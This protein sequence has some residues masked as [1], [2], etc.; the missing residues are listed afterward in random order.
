VI[1]RSI[2]VTD[3]R[4]FLEDIE[5]GPFEEGLSII[6]APNGTGKSTLFEA[7]RRALLDGHKVTGKD[8]EAI[9]PWGRN[10]APKVTIEFIHDRQE[11]RITKQFIDSP[12]A[13]LERK[14][15]GRYRRLAEGA[16]ADEQ[17]REILTKNPP[18]KGLAKTPNW[19]IAQVLWAPQGSLAIGPLTGDVVSDIQRMLSA[20]VSNG[21]TGPVEKR[22]EERYFQLFSAKGK[23]K[24]GKDAPPLARLHEEIE[25]A[26][27]AR[28]KAYDL[29]VAFE[30]TSQR[31]EELRARRTQARYNVE[32]TMKA[33]R[34]A[35]ALA[36]T[37]RTLLAERNERSERVNATEAQYKELKRRIDLIKSTERDLGEAQKR[38]ITLG[39]EVPL[40][41]REVQE[42]EKEATR[43]K[44]ELE[45]IR[46]GRQ[47]VDTAIQMADSARRFN[48]CSR[49][50]RRSDELISKIE[51]AE[52]ALAESRTKRNAQI[53]PD[54]RTLKAIRKSIKDRDDAQLRIE[55]SL[56]TLE[57]VPNKDG[58]VEVVTGEV[59]G[60]VPLKASAPTQVRGSPEV[61]VEIPRVARL[62]AWGPVGSVE[63]HREAR[64][65]AE[66]KLKEL[67][68]PFGTSDVDA[69][70][71]LAEKGKEL[72]ASVAEAYTKLQTLLAGRT[73]DELVQDRNIFETVYR[74][75]LA[76]YPDWGKT[77]PDTDTLDERAENEKQI[78]ITRVEN[79]EAA[80]DKARSALTAASGQKETLSQR[81][82]DA[83][84]QVT[85]LREK[86]AELTSDGKSL[87]EREVELQRSTMSWEA[88]RTRLVGIQGQL[89]QYEDD[90][91]AVVD[92]LEAQVEAANQE[93]SQARE[94]EVREETKLEGLC[95]QG[96]YSAISISE[97]RVS[98]LQE[99]IRRDELHVEAIRLLH[100][101]VATCRSEAIAAVSKPVE[102]MATRTLQRI[103]GR[104]L[105]R[106]QVGEA[107]E[108]STVVPESIEEAVTLDN[109]SGGEQEQLYLATRL[110]L[111][112]VLGREER[113]LV[114]LDDVLT[115]TDAG[116]LAKV[117]NVL[118][119]VAQ[120]LQ[121]LIL[122]CHP[123]RY[124]SLKHAAFFDLE[125]L[126]ASASSS[127]RATLKD[128]FN[129]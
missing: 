38:L 124:R 36:D 48:E 106:V 74:S 3:W 28:Q 95:A 91:L 23:L 13:L 119:E 5:V 118:E 125:G 52:K 75:F 46:K 80:W 45:D 82:E 112:E 25:K 17:T 110:A 54:A 20:Q 116:R 34:N 101:T 78:F 70:E 83:K 129:E 44:A 10:L 90:P 4:C 89:E 96:P 59:T 107:F 62:R 77:V 41:D 67:T 57:I 122:T 1:I 114:V 66:K 39:S 14:E 99:E 42:R 24:T 98:Q 27:A 8:V 12:S 26:I 123:E 76:T 15:N 115:A 53:A 88:A 128:R 73:L 104:R 6:H 79:A 58:F 127:S 49:E 55:A 68:D 81:L 31:V 22:I 108:P 56:I 11:Y 32:E 92:R 35:R 51:K 87:Q 100:D 29:Y 72:D 84:R 97:E 113:Q 64:A 71:S 94:Q 16:F 121:I 85:T 86:L 120:H 111:A 19:G 105:G 103:A 33:L 117:M 9:R 50:L 47:A 93:S 18:G 69:L 21:G 102:A 65:K 63:E 109:I 60:S 2:K 40:K 43:L 61:V 126:I 7:L 37:Y 30:K